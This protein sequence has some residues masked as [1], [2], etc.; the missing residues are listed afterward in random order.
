[1]D[2]YGR[3]RRRNSEAFMY[4]MPMKYMNKETNGW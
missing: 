1:M 4:I 3:E 2:E